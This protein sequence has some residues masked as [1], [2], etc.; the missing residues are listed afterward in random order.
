MVG[1]T[2]SREVYNHFEDFWSEKR[3]EFLLLKC[4]PSWGW[5]TVP[6]PIHHRYQLSSKNLISALYWESKCQCRPNAWKL[7]S[8]TAARDPVAAKRRE[9]KKTKNLMQCLPCFMKFIFVSEDFS[10][11][12]RTQTD[13]KLL[14]DSSAKL[15]CHSF[16]SWT[17]SSTT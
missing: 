17:K 1:D 16:A 6:C 13:P 10:N 12:W 7:P 4:L 9:G 2:F 15:L 11:T 3:G 5:G 8:K 14:Q